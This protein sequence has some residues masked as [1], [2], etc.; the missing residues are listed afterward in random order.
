MRSR[1]IAP[2]AALAPAASTPPIQRLERTLMPPAATPA[3]APAAVPPPLSRFSN[4]K[5]SLQVSIVTSQSKPGSKMVC[6]E[7]C[8]G[9]RRWISAAIYGCDRPLLTFIYPDRPLLT[10]IYPGFD[11]G[12]A[13]PAGKKLECACGKNVMWKMSNGVKKRCSVLMNHISCSSPRQK[14]RRS[15]RQLPTSMGS[16]H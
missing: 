14:R 11:C 16:W 9:L 5:S 15:S 3:T 13:W 7:L 8:T 10:F 2:P 4:F 12:S 1:A 6:P